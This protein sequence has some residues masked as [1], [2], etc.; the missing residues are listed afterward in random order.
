VI[1]ILVF[2]PEGQIFGTHTKKIGNTSSS[3]LS[4]SEKACQLDS[5][6]S[7]GTGYDEVL[8]FKVW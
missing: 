4:V 6:Q 5:E 7:P 8:A 2:L 3:Y 1:F